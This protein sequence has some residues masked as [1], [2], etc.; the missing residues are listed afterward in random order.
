MVGATA[1]SDVEEPG[2][3]S[4]ALASKLMLERSESSV[5]LKSLVSSST[6]NSTKNDPGNGSLTAGE[7]LAPILNRGSPNGSD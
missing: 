7:G 6:N 3:N 5:P 2:I 1:G 4:A